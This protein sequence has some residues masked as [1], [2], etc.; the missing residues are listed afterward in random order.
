MKKVL[1]WSSNLWCLGA[2]KNLGKPHI[3]YVI[4]IRFSKKN[5]LQMWPPIPAWPIMEGLCTDKILYSSKQ[6]PEQ[7]ST[8]AL[9]MKWRTGQKERAMRKQ[10]DP[11]FTSSAKQKNLLWFWSAALTILLLWVVD[12]LQTQ[13]CNRQPRL[14]S[15]F[16]LRGLNSHV[17]LAAGANSQTQQ[18]AWPKQP[19]EIALIPFWALAKSDSPN[20]R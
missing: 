7:I 9:V 18:P 4:R 10:C 16:R 17:T 11:N 6:R 8:A 1:S 13:P 3:K 2:I 20:R 5:K 15:R 19:P 14:D 12:F